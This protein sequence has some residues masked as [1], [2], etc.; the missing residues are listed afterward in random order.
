L[1]AV[2]P[3]GEPVELVVVWQA[4]LEDVF[5]PLAGFEVVQPVLERLAFRLQRQQ[6]RSLVWVVELLLV[7]YLRVSF[8]VAKWFWA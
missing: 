4:R 2:T 5:R 7:L 1:Q 3:S 6:V 8:L